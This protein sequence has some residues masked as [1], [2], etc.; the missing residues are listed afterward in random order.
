MTMQTNPMRGSDAWGQPR[1]GACRR[2]Q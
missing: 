2:L 1:A